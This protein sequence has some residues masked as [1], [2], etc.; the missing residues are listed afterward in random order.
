MRKWVRLGGEA[1]GSMPLRRWPNDDEA[2]TKR[3]N[4]FGYA[5]KKS[6]S[7]RVVFFDVASPE[8]RSHEEMDTPPLPLL[9]SNAQFIPIIHKPPPYLRHFNHFCLVFENK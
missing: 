5:I 4:P 2:A 6:H 9:P 3:A 7:L 8:I 1:D